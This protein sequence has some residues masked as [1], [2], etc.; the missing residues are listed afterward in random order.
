MR[1]ECRVGV[2]VVP[3]DQRISAQRFR[4]LCRQRSYTYP[5]LARD[6]RKRG[7]P[8]SRA[9][10]ARL[11][12]EP[13]QPL[14]CYAAELA[15]ILKSTVGYLTGHE[16]QFLGKRFRDLYR[17]R[18]C[19]LAVLAG[20]LY[21]R[22]HVKV[23]AQYLQQLASCR[24]TNPRE[25]IV[26]GLAV[27]LDTT[28]DYLTG[29]EDE[30]C[31]HDP[32]LPPAGRDEPVP[33]RLIAARGGQDGPSSNDVDRVLRAIAEQEQREGPPSHNG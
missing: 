26:D 24:N 16:R 25:E 27:L 9:G 5:E 20:E 1:P 23:S 7:I 15:R 33:A 2:F 10:L 29:C 14:P 22:W 19:S 30:R 18:G 13:D 12:R 31:G 3:G 32:A 11:G 4:L 21:R 17:Q 8:V 6:L 28:A